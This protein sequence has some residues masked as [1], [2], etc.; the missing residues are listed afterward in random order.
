MEKWNIST[1]CLCG[2]PNTQKKKKNQQGTL[3]AEQ[4]GCDFR[5]TDVCHHLCLTA[6]I[7]HNNQIE[8]QWED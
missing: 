7:K 5:V 4:C 3:V 6:K 2:S 1:R 8:Y